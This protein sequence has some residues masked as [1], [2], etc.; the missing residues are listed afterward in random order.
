[1]QKDYALDTLLDL[2]QQILVQEGGYWIKIEA[3]QV[4]P[5][6]HI[7]HGIRYSLTLHD[8]NGT[9]VLGYD[10]AHSVKPS[11]FKYAG[12]VLPYDHKH[13]SS[14]DKGVPYEFKDPQQLLQDFFADVD[15]VLEQVKK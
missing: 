12:Q 13:R 6:E 8:G 2:H 4:L 15:R 11:K 5:S 7:P 3:H 10:N 9:R 14:E 1:M